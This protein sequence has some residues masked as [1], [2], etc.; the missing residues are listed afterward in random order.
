MVTSY[1]FTVSFTQFQVTP[2]PFTIHIMSSSFQ[3]FAQDMPPNS[4]WFLPSWPSVAESQSPKSPSAP[5][6]ALR[7]PCRSAICSLA[8]WCWRG[9]Y[10]LSK[11]ANKMQKKTLE[12]DWLAMRD[13]HQKRCQRKTHM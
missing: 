9:C 10:F 8:W 3:D 7:W 6:L 13:G 11:N 4:G 2:G 12:P 1:S 5:P